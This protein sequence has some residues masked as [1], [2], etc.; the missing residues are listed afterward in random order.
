MKI[1][2]LLPTLEFGGVERGTVDLSEALVN[3]NHESIVVSGGGRMTKLLHQHEARHIDLNISKKSIYSFMKY[4]RLADIY[5]DLKPDIVHIRSRFPAWIHM[6]AMN[7]LSK[8]E[9]PITVSTF[10]GLYSKP[11]YSKSMAKAD[12]IISVS[13]TV[14]DYI[15]NT[16]KISPEEV[17]NIYRGCDTIKFNKNQLNQEWLDQWYKEYPTTRNKKILLM[18]TR[19]TSWKGIEYFLE[20]LSLLQDDA[21][22]GL[23]V[24]PIPKNKNNYFKRLLSQSRRLKLTDQNL[25]FTGGRD[26]IEEVYKLSDVVFNLSTKPEPFGRTII[27]AVA[28][29]CSVVGWN[30]GGVNESLSEINSSGIVQ[31]GDLRQLKDKTLSL[32]ENPDNLVLPD[33]FTKQYQTTR[34]I[35]LYQS[36]L[37]R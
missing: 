35:E 4:K 5:K 2:Q 36:L 25:V 22:C 12:A 9:K 3:L 20:L 28:S 19:I 6:F 27:E 15:S 13:R 24:G 14:K 32:L 11:W 8:S 18:P 17:T 26:D 16:Y 33:I 31:Y 37:T 7:K 30:R 10:H 23:I 29:G 21:V 1:I 34:T